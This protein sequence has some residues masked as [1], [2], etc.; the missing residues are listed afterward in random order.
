MVA[1]K[2]CSMG[3]V[4]LCNYEGLRSEPLIAALPWKLVIA[5]ESTEFKG[6]KSKISK[7]MTG[8]MRIKRGVKM[9]SFPE[10]EHRAILTGSIAPED[11]RDIFNQFK[12]VDGHFMGY[13]DAWEWLVKHAQKV[14]W[15]WHFTYKARKDIERYVHENSYILRRRDVNIGSKKLRQ[16][17]YIEPSSELLKAMRVMKKR[18]L[19]EFGD[20]DV[21]YLKYVVQ[22][23]NFLQRLAEGFDPDKKLI[24]RHKIDELV[25]LLKGELEGEKA[26]VWFWSNSA[27]RATEEALTNLCMPR[28]VLVGS[29]TQEERKEALWFCEHFKGPVVLLAQGRLGKYGLDCSWCDTMI[30]YSR[31]W[32]GLINTQ[33]EDRFIHPTQNHQKLI[34]DLVTR[35]S[36][37]EVLV[38]RNRYKRINSKSLASRRDI[39]QEWMNIANS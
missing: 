1:D 16:I 24:S 21:L 38:N 12:F 27:L 4:V 39:I 5:D 13:T 6:W 10:A 28:K 31:W 19:Y 22:V 18:F 11:Y 20:G 29:S 23:Q 9:A 3:N 7:I 15:E 2:Y 25:K 37:D 8:E 30:Y 32:S 34:I 26:V 14:G 33:S 36:T 35:K 17:R